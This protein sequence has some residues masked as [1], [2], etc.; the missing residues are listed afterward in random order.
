MSFQLRKHHLHIN[1]NFKSCYLFCLV[2]KEK[3]NFK[4]FIKD[5]S[6]DQKAKIFNRQ[7]KLYK[8]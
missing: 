2:F 3:D 6:K 1:Q 4:N 5:K 7:S 8:Y